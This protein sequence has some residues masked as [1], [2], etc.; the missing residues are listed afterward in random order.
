MRVKIILTALIVFISA[1]LSI[2][3]SDWLHNIS[4]KAI[5]RMTSFVISFLIV[6]SLLVSLLLV[7]KAFREFFK[8]KLGSKIRFR[9]IVL[10][11]A[12]SLIS[13]LLLS[14]IFVLVI[15]ALKVTI[16]SREGERVSDISK[17]MLKELSWYYKEVFSDLEYSLKKVPQK[18]V[19]VLTVT[20]YEYSGDQIVSNILEHI[21][22]STMD[23][24]RSIVVVEDKEYA[25]AF[26]KSSYLKVAYVQIDQSKYNLKRGLSKILQIS[27]NSEFLFYDILEKYLPVIL[28]LLNIPSLFVSILVAYLFSEYISRGISRLSEGIAEVSKGNLEYTISERGA[29][30]EIKD[31]VREFNRMTLKLLEAQ[32]RISKIE[33]ME[34]WKDIARKVA[35]EIKNPLTPIKLSIQRILANPDVEDFKERVLSSL[36]LIIEEI[37]RINN[38]VTQLSNFAKIPPPM[39]TNFKFTDLMK[40][41]RELFSGQG[42]EIECFVNGEDSMYA[43]FDQMK[44]CLMNLIKNGIEASQGISNRIVVRFLKN[45]DTVVISVRDFGVGIPEELRDKILNPYI[46][47][48]KTGSGLG[49]SIVETIV[50]NHKGKLYFESEVGKGSEFFIE[51]P[52][53]G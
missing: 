47:T 7:I 30:D 32:Y 12:L 49:L 43:D 41:I 23:R 34:L 5:N 51:L 15:D 28:L 36:S 26:E 14:S 22:S 52:L 37:D 24:G 3:L 48:K 39:P 1:I 16:E 31:L 17:S 19:K 2:F 42:V 13:T 38:L 27:S 21:K 9:L 45:S 53:E 18:N 46:T 50:I 33:K 25:F 6:S 29:V 4:L 20:A 40:D 8:R 44:Q 10:F 35:H 11:L